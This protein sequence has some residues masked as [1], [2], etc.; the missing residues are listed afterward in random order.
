MKITTPLASSRWWNLLRVGSLVLGLHFGCAAFAADV[1]GLVGYWQFEEGSGTSVADQS[2][3]GFNGAFDNVATWGGP[4]WTNSPLGV[5]ALSFDGVNDRVIVGNPI[6]LQITGPMTL[7]AWVN[8]RAFNQNGRIVTK[9]GGSG[10]RGWALNVEG[11]GSPANCGSFQVAANATTTFAIKTTTSIPSNQWIHLAG[12]YVPGESVRIYTNGFFNNE[13]T[14]GVPASQNNPNLNV[15][16]GARPTGSVDTPWQGLIDEVRIF[17]R[18]LSEEE[19]RALPEVAQTP[20]AFS[21]QPVS[22]RVAELR[23]VTFSAAVTG[24]PPHLYQWLLN[25]EPIE[26]ATES[27]YTIPS[28]TIDMSGWE[29]AVVVSNLAY[30]VTSSNAVLEVVQDFEPPTLVSAGSADGLTLGL[31]FSEPLDPSLI[32]E[33]FFSINNGIVPQTAWFDADTRR[34]ILTLADGD[35]VSGEFSVKVTGVV[36]LVWNQIVSDAPVKGEVA[37]LTAVDLGVPAQPGFTVSYKSG[38]FELTAGGADLWGSYDQGHAVL[39]ALNGDFDRSVRVTGLAPVNSIAKAGLMVRETLDAESPT[40]HL[41]VNP[42][43]P[44][45]RGWIQAGRRASA[46]GSTATWGANFTAAVIPDVWVRLR[47]TGDL[48]SGYYS[49]NGVDWVLMGQAVQPMADPVWVGLAATAHDNGALPTVAQFRGLGPTPFANAMLNITQSPA[50]TSVEQNADATLNVLAEGTGAPAAEMV[51]QWQRGDGAGGFGNLPNANGPSLQFLARPTDNGAQFRALVFFAGLTRTSQVATL[52]VTPDTLRPTMTLVS[53]RGNPNQ[54]KV[55]FSEAID[56]ASAAAPG[57]YTLSTPEG[58]AIDLLEAV[59]DANGRTVMLTTLE[60]LLEDA[61]YT[62]SVSGIADLGEPPQYIVPGSRQ[63]FTFSSL[64][65]HWSFEEGSGLTAT[66]SVSGFVGT[67]LNGSMWVDGPSGGHALEF[68]GSNDRVDVGN[69]PELQMTGPLTV[70]AWV[71]VDT[72]AGNGRIVTKGGASGQR[73]WS[74]NVEGT[75]MWAFQVALSGTAN[76]SLNVP[77]V[78]LGVWVHVAGVYDPSVPVMRFYV[79]GVLG[80]EQ[81]DGVPAAQFNSPIAVGI[82]A[83]ANDSNFWD[84]KIDEVRI[85]ARALYD[86]EIAAIAVP[87]VE[88]KFLLPVV[89]GN[90]VQLDWTGAGQLLW[91]PSVIGPWTPID[92]QPT[93]PYTETITP[94]QIR[95]FRLKAAQ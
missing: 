45:G 78:P 29:F 64:V 24:A 40:L 86:T 30:S 57:N 49:L 3:N 70:A 25:G 37:G 48:F 80:G 55:V 21:A 77:G 94:G 26:G 10:S 68:D 22:R 28:T 23:S 91:A 20:L 85:Y 75:D 2:G 6:A 5:Y 62:L 39:E 72:I 79:N 76:V 13:I 27:T 90:Q 9:G 51:Y 53:A 33:S 12:V 56:A 19:I 67:L 59:L 58:A 36:D 34:I 61:A 93:P 74:L 11:S 15:A 65:A 52:T 1:P 46:G 83:R 42:P 63:N 38:E 73:G 82:G 35:R 88:L 84:G 89:S 69:P 81:T 47:R 66:D 43:S 31:E 71:W 60:P 8:A 54:I 44:V 50:N 41:L 95:F 16:I 17:N 32:A 7:T 87:P 18:A 4:K 14:T 92:P